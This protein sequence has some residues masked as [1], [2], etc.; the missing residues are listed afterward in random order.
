MKKFL[1]FML[2]LAMIASMMCVN[3]SAANVVGNRKGPGV[4]GATYGD[5]ALADFTSTATTT[6]IQ[7]ALD[8]SVTHRYSVDLVYTAETIF[9]TSDAQWNVN[10]LKYDGTMTAK[11]GEN[12]EEQELQNEE[13]IES[14]R[15]FTFT[16]YSDAPVYITA[17]VQNTDDLNSEN[18]NYK[19]ISTE[20]KVFVGGTSSEITESVAAVIEGVT[21]KVDAE[22]EAVTATYR[23]DL[24]CDDW[25]ANFASLTLNNATHTI[26]VANITFK[27]S[28]SAPT[29]NPTQGE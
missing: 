11:V 3:V 26:N 9:I 25:A 19:N 12:G 28:S 1:S 6:N 21:P 27:I 4:E 20:T 8:G 7:V 5:G 14:V 16:N 22:G 15:T 24:Y 18:A 23:A 13:P 2:V 10:T 29:Q 17:T